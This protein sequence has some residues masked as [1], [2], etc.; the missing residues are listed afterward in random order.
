MVQRKVGRYEI[1]GELG[2]GGMATVYRA[3]DPSFGRDVAIKVL[4]RELLHDPGFRARFEREAKI[5]AGL[6]HPAIVPVYDYGDE[7]GQPYIVM[8]LM[9]GGSLS[10]QLNHGPV[11]LKKTIE[12]VS[13]LCRALDSAHD[14]GI[15][16]RDLKPNN[17][18]L[19]KDDEPYI[20]DFGIAKLT[21]ESSTYSKSA[22]IGTPAYMSPEQWYGRDLDRRCDVYALGVVTFELLAGHLPFHGDSPPAFM[23]KHLME[24]VPNVRDANPHLPVEIQSVLERAMAKSKEAR[25]ATAGEMSNALAAIRRDAPAITRELAIVPPAIA[26]P[27]DLGFE[28][29]GLQGQLVGWFNGFRFV[30][31]VSTAYQFQLLPRGDEVGG[32][33]VAMHNPSAGDEEFG[34]LMQRCPAGYLVGK[35]VKFEGEIALQDVTGHAGIWLRADGTRGVLFFANMPVDPV[36]G[37]RA[38]TKYSLE[39]RIPDGTKW[40]N[41]GVLLVGRGVVRADRFRLLAQVARGDWVD[42]NKWDWEH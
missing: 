27:I 38:W 21:A 28:L 8:R 34:S 15:I 17:L 39:A 24:Q 20:A 6:E 13:R 23:T 36:R 22:I 32:T 26:K 14:R 1:N 29:S 25:F 19:D 41:Y 2:R 5:I 10:D 11:P 30:A 3:F 35:S 33:C 16:H 40:L 31:G 12:I 18:L 4:P 42:L 37:T 9:Q 7:D